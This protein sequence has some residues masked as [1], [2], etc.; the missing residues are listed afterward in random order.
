MR[1]YCCCNHVSIS[2][3]DTQEVLFFP[4]MRPEEG[5]KD[6]EAIAQDKTTETPV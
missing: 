1:V 5:K 6:T 2:M 3:S 4:A